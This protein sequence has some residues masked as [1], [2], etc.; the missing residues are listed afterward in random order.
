MHDSNKAHTSNDHRQ[1]HELASQCK[2]HCTHMFLVPVQ[3][4]P[5]LG[6]AKQ[7]GALRNK[8]IG[9][10]YVSK[11]TPDTTL[12]KV[13]DSWFMLKCRDLTR[14]QAAMREP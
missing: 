3:T 14:A 12:G 9:H 6:I 7:R 1:R 2:T 8:Y 10:T 4:Q 5:P 13:P 11:D